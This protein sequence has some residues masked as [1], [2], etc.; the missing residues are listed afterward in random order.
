MQVAGLTTVIRIAAGSDFSVALK[1]DGTVW[2]W[3]NN[4]HGALGPGGGS[5][6]FT[7]HPNPIKVTG[8]STA[9]TEIS[10]GNEFVLALANNSIVWSWGNNGFGQLG[11]G[12][13]FGA[14]STPQAI[15][16]LSGIVAVA[17][18]YE[19]GVALKNDG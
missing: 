8:L 4:F 9:I 5:N 18:G 16:N 12:P 11:Q 14:N 1:D 19:H 10:A 15:P 13:D 2:A 6:D 17:G 7:P 3:G